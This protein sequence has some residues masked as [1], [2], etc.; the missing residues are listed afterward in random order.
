MSGGIVPDAAGF[1]KKFPAIRASD[2]RNSGCVLSGLVMARSKS[3]EV[4]GV[5]V[6]EAA[7]GE[8]PPERKVLSFRGILL[9]AEGG[10]SN[11]ANV[12]GEVNDWN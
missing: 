5:R 8:L 6:W 10:Q 11:A 1:M 2:E 9:P 3:A 4:P 7:F 12:A